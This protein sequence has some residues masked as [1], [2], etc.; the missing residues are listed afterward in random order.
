VN[1]LQ[2]TVLITAGDLGAYLDSNPDGFV[3]AAGAA[4]AAPVQSVNG[5]S[6]TVL[7][8]A[9][10]VGAYPDDNPA[11]YI[12]AAGAP[13]QSVN[14]LQG[15]VLLDAAAVGAYPDDNPA[16]YIDASGAPV[17]SVNGASGTVVLVASDVGAV[18]TAVGVVVYDYGT[19]IPTFRPDAAAVYWR[20]TAAPGTAIALAGDIWFDTTGD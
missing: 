14:G 7:L 4:A 2:G 6:G 15:T 8:D 16:G 20:G 3:D 12:D 5:L 10:A 18:G 13:V 9:A 17:Q 19:A 1:G 11:G